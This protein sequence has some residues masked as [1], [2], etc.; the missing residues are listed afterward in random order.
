MKKLLSL[1][2][3]VSMLITLAACGGESAQE[4][5]NVAL[6]KR[7]Y[8]SS[9][10]LSNS[11]GAIQ[12][13]DGD[14]G[15]AW[16][17]NTMQKQIDEWIM[18]DLGKNY[19]ID[20]IT[21]KWGTSRAVDYSIEISRG[22]VEFEEIHAAQDV[23]STDDE[24]ITTDKV[25]RFVRIRCTKVPPVLM[26]F[27]G[28]AIRELEVIGVEAKDQTLGSETERMLIT[29]TVVPAENDVYV[30]GRNYKYNELI[31]AGAVYEYKCTGP[32]AGAI[33]G[34]SSGQFEVSIDG[35][36][37]VVYKNEDSFSKEY[38]FSNE[39]DPDKEHVVRIMKS[40]DVWAAKVAIEGVIV[41]ENSDVVK[42]YTRE[43]DLKIEFLGDSITSGVKTPTYS[44]SYVYRTAEAFNANFN[45]VSRSGQGLYKHANLGNNGNLK[46][47]YA[48]TGMETGDY[49][50][51]YD[52]DLV[53]LHIGTNDG[54]NVNKLPTAEEK[55][56]YREKFTEMYVEMLEII[57]E[58]NPNAIIL[59]T[60]GMM[61]DFN[62]V[63][64]QVKKAVDL[65]KAQNPDV[66]VYLKYLTVAKDIGEST[67]WHPGVDGH[68]KGAE[69]LI[70]IIE[71]ILK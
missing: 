5:T 55:N 41:E 32:V 48:G 30:M 33:V 42:D 71:N 59:C 26:T 40:G 29:K 61:G 37:F 52:A 64:T 10:A 65:Y 24:T 53:V 56:A 9:E 2:L 67:S 20:S 69:E 57:H 31:W 36:E 70:K 51:G 12:V 17:S 22:G 60:G 58:K 7:V 63:R 45:V 28:A 27:M 43:Y 44:Q 3:A 21:L 34:R 38:I 50:Y 66:K 46:T 23:T 68:T 19:D 39:L 4:P 62:S 13:N 11:M 47:L 6:N 15:T 14:D 49:E 8:C 25:A 18:V 35:G 16:A 54:A 1:I